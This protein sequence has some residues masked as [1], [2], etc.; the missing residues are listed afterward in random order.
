MCVAV[1]AAGRAAQAT[2]TE[3]ERNMRK[4]VIEIKDMHIDIGAT[5]TFDVEKSLGVRIG[6]PV[7]PWS[8][9]QIMGNISC[10]KGQG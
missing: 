5:R 10:K 3:K 8:P 4:K 1:L 6:D 9:F 7:I 2:D